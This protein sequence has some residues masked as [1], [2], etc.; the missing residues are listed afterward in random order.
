MSLQNYV[1]HPLT[2]LYKTYN[3]VSPKQGSP[4]HSTS[5]TLGHYFWVIYYSTYVLME[6]TVTIQQEIIHFI[7]ILHHLSL[8]NSEYSYIHFPSGTILNITQLLPVWNMDY[9]WQSQKP[10]PIIFLHRLI[11][12]I[13]R[14]LPVYVRVQYLTNTHTSH[15]HV[16]KKRLWE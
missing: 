7:F 1:Q 14:A 2:L 5:K 8:L 11:V 15:I 10:S 6:T 13:H 16:L 3:S 9:I 4:V 12:N